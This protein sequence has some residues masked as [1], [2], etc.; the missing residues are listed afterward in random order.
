MNRVAAL[1]ILVLLLAGGAL[2]ARPEPLPHGARLDPHLEFHEDDSA[3]LTLKISIP[4]THLVFRKDGDV[5]RASLRTAVTL[6][7]RESEREQN[8]V[9]R[10][11]LLRHS[12][13]AARDP[14][15]LFEAQYELEILSG[16]LEVDVLIYGRGPYLPWKESFPLD[17]PLPGSRGFFLQGPRFEPVEGKASTPPFGFH[18]PWNIPDRRSLFQDGFA[19][20]LGIYAELKVWEPSDSLEAV[21]RLEE[22]DGHLVH[23][24]RR[25][26]P[27]HAGSRQ[28][29][30]TLPL[31]DLSM[32]PHRLRLSVLRD[33]E[34]Q[35]VQG[36]LEMG[37]GPAAFGRDW[38]LT[39]DLLA[40][41]A[42]PRE[43]ELMEA[44]EADRRHGVFLEFWER[45][46]TEHGEGNP[47]MEAFFR[48]L[49][50]V[51]RNF[52]TPWTPGWRSDRGRI[53]L[54]YGPPA[55]VDEL[56]EDASFR[57]RE[58]WSYAGGMIFVFEDRHGQGDFEL[59]ERWSQ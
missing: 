28:M 27:G 42:D 10:E 23:Y 5:Y 40:H 56:G 57:A 45:R 12:F 53:Y 19:R 48:D 46:D 6:R 33:G 14:E 3:I 50:H 8:A 44:A 7:D 38:G 22:R 17:L 1:S 13:E 4:V 32:G 2:A 25:M 18:D 59:V 41:L 51:G 52:G 29:R 24:E 16:E 55:Q 31:E 20:R 34:S 43:L 11:D 36:R 39:L 26:L 15:A 47:A 21:L 35:E 49:D 54:E 37:L 30:F 58:I 9:F